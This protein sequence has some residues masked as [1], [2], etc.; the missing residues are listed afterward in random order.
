[1][2]VWKILLFLE[3]EPNLIRLWVWIFIPIVSAVFRNL[4]TGGI[5][6]ATCD[7]DAAQMQWIIQQNKPEQHIFLINIFAVA[8]EL[9][10]NIISRDM[11]VLASAD[12]CF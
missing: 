11:V 3:L 10:I 12:S 2:F 6:P 4:H 7:S 1:M 8:L 9:N 5:S